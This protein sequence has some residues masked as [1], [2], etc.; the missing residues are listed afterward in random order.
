MMEHALFMRGL[1]DPS[2]GELIN[3]SNDFAIKF[4]ELIEKTNK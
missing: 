3:T 4:N 1:L 2:E